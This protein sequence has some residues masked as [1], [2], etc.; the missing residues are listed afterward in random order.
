MVGLTFGVEECQPAHWCCVALR[1]LRPPHRQPRGAVGAA[2]GRVQAA[3]AIKRE[4]HRR[5]GAGGAPG[6][7]RAWHAFAACRR[8]LLQ[9][10]YRRQTRPCSARA[11]LVS[12]EHDVGA[13]NP[14]DRLCR[15]GLRIKRRLVGRAWRGVPHGGNGS[16]L[17]FTT[18][19]NKEEWDVRACQG[20]CSHAMAF[21]SCVCNTQVPHRCSCTP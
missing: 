14:L 6:K 15:L 12:G 18:N 21:Y 2:T 19:G 20:I 4:S 17:N 11:H 3:N 1:R 9:K 7:S 13:G 10:A 8:R 5:G 16:R